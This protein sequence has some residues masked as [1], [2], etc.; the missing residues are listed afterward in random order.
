MS[1]KKT[2]VPRPKDAEIWA[3]I[4]QRATAFEKVC[5]IDKEITKTRPPAM[6][7]KMA[8]KIVDKAA[9]TVDMATSECAKAEMAFRRSKDHLQ[10][11]RYLHAKSKTSLDDLEIH[12]KI[13]EDSYSEAVGEYKYCPDCHTNDYRLLDA[14]CRKCEEEEEEEEEEE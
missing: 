4:E 2:P 3:L 8:R 6:Y 7:L 14:P 1:E 11:V 12:M 5:E 10:E 13:A 9:R